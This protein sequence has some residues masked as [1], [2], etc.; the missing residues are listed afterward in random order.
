[1]EV[2]ALLVDM[3]G[4]VVDSSAAVT[5]VWTDY[6]AGRGLDIG[7]VLA[8]AHGRRPHETIARFD[9]ADPDPAA[10]AQRLQDQ[11]M[12]L[13]EGIS[14]VTGARDLWHGIGGGQSGAKVALVTSASRPLAEIRMAAAGLAMPAVAV[15]AEDVAAGK[16]APDGYLAAARAL[17]VAITD[18]LVLED[19][20]AGIEAALTAGAKLIAVGGRPGGPGELG[21][22]NRLAELPDL[23][24]LGARVLESGRIEVTW[25]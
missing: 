12:A 1:V 23:A 17:G 5:K 11:E 9:P 24:G 16:P 21:G 14:P 15:C 20:L 18:C 25:P 6:A 7:Q 4:T 10:T 8:F 13:R 22:P 19:S 2:G 3:D